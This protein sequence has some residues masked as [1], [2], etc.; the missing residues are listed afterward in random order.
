MHDTRAWLGALLTAGLLASCDQYA[1]E[2]RDVAR[3]EQ[4]INICTETVPSNRFVDGIPAYAQCTGSQNSAIYSNNGV[5]TGTTSGGTDWVRTQYSGGYQCTELAHRYLQALPEVAKGD[6]NKVWVIP[7]ELT[8][9][10]A[11][12][13]DGLNGT[14]L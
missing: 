4:A 1:T 5:D 9:A 13:R 10:L 14:G 11:R 2:E 3:V 12:L 6:A 7:A 8:T